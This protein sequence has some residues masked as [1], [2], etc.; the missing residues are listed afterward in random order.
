MITRGRLG[1][2]AWSQRSVRP[3]RSCARR[4][5]A[6]DNWRTRAGLTDRSD[7][8]G[9]CHWLLGL[10]DEIAA[11]IR[12]SETEKFSFEMGLEGERVCNDRRKDEEEKRKSQ[13][14]VLVA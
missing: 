14:E 6:G 4:S 8:G 1:R 2:L 13:S 7:A 11:P 12:E 5:A 3:A 10:D 9:S